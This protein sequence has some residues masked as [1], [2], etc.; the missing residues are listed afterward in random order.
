MTRVDVRR[1]AAAAD[2]A[3]PR[4][5]CAGS[6]G[7]VLVARGPTSPRSTGSI[8]DA[9]RRR[10]GARGAGARRPGAAGR[11]PRP[12]GDGRVYLDHA[13]DI[14]AFNPC[15][16]EYEIAR[17]RRSRRRARSRSRSP[18]RARRA[19]STAGSSPLFFDCVVQHHNCD[20]GRGR[21][22]HLARRCATGG[23]RR[24]SPRSRFDGRA[25]RVDDGRIRSTG[26]AARRRA[27]CC[28]RRRSSAV[29][30]DRADLPEV[31][32]RRSRRVTADGDRRRRR[33]PA[34]GPRAAA[35]A[36][37]ERAATSVLLVCDDDVLTYA[38]R[39]APVG[40]A[41][42]RPARRRAPG[43][44][45]RVGHPAPERQRRSSWRGSPPPGSARSSVPLS[46]FST[47]AEL[48]GPAAQRRRRAA[49][50]RAGRTGRTTTRPRCAA[51]SPSSTSAAPPP[52]LAD[53]VPVAAPHRLRRRRAPA[54]IP[55]GRWRSLAARGRSVGPTCSPRPRR[56]S[57][58]ADRMVIVHTSGSTSEPKGVIHT[59]GA[60]IR[61]LDNLNQIRR[62]APGEV[63]FSNSP[64]FWIG[65][66]AY[67]LLGTLV[68]GRDAR[69]LERAATPPACSTCS[70]ASGRRWSTGSRQS[71]A[72]LPRR[73][74]AS[75]GRDLS[76]IRR[77]QPLPD[78]ARRRA[79]RRPRAAPRDARHDRDRQRVPGER[80][81]V[82]PARAP[83]RLVRPA[84]RPGSRPRS[85]TPSTGADCGPGEAGELWFRGPVPDGGLLRPR[86]PRGLRRR[87]LVPHRRPRRPSTTTASSTSRAA[88][89]T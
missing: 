47:S 42:P 81:R 73:P 64:F 55:A 45:T 44:G 8:A 27:S 7:L 11:A 30:G 18:T 16:P 35:R 85:S 22:D 5:C 1:R 65:G 6:T 50:E 59:H 24:C 77:G 56:R 60:L 53:S 78:H 15:F 63:L 37:R 69:V 80:R 32:P 13:R 88:A 76:S 34:H 33:P 2:R 71:V 54:S 31:S 38:R 46:T 14:G 23:R 9:A 89:A 39:R 83:A 17:R 75:R 66:F 10:G 41:R 28:A 49:A 82:R 48:R 84:G 57:A 36:G 20:V 87:R 4:R 74:D 79:A 72:H 67:S 61:H 86:A 52:L 43:Q 26:A 62:Y 70:S 58:P 51:A 40:R 3:R 25:R 21:Q 19:S 12:R 29:A 68:A